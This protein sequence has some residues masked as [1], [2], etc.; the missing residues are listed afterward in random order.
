MQNGSLTGRRL[1]IISVHIP[2]T[3][4]TIFLRRVLREN[5][6]LVRT[7]Y[8]KPYLDHEQA[9]RDGCY[10]IHGHFPASL[11]LDWN[12]PY[13][14]WLR[15]P[16][17]RMVSHFNWSKRREMFLDPDKFDWNE[18]FDEYIFENRNVISKYMDIPREKFMFVGILERWSES[19]RRFG[20]LVDI[21]F[22]KYTAKEFLTNVRNNYSKK[23]YHCLKPRDFH[24]E[25]IRHY[26]QKDIQFYEEERSKYD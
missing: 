12:L 14:V 18:V 19:L 26:N 13:I 15:D 16:V 21:N 8:K 1:D 7:D 23:N 9:L 25:L 17:T 2:K 10:M 22:D 6:L 11:Y 5:F 3:G 4:G 24:L 20:N